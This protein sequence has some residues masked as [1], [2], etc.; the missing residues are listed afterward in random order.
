MHTGG[1]AAHAKFLPRPD[2]AI[3]RPA[4]QFFIAHRAAPPTLFHR[5][6]RS[7]TF[8]RGKI[9]RLPHL[10][11]AR[12]EVPAISGL[13]AGRGFDSG[14]R[15]QP[16]AAGPYKASRRQVHKPEERNK[17]GIILS[18]MVGASCTVAPHGEQRTDRNV[19]ATQD[20]S[21][22]TAHRQECLCYREQEA[23]KMAALLAEVEEGDE[24]EEDGAEGGEGGEDAEPGEDE[25]AFVFA[26]RRRGNAED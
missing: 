17:V 20:K 13:W 11:L 7:N 22:R 5:F 9:T 14:G 10:P 19:C 3:R 18:D 4:F 23:G 1:V 26:G 24:V 8:L 2:K 16:A 12:R 15:T 6:I 25:F 21:K